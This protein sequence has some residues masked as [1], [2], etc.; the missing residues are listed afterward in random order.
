MKFF[1]KNIKLIIFFFA[2]NSLMILCQNFNDNTL[3]SFISSPKLIKNQL[4]SFNGI[5]KLNMTYIKCNCYNGFTKD[6]NIR[7]INNYDVDCSYFLKSRLIALVLSLIIP[8]GVDYFYLGHYIIG[9]LIFV[10]VLAIIAINIWLLNWVLIYDRLTSVGNVDRIFE[11]K[12]LVLKCT[13]AI[14]DTIFLILYI[15][16]GIFQGL[17]IIKDSNGFST[18][19]DFFLEK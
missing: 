9:F 3:D 18:N 14:I 15:I 12:Y 7:K 2:L 4:C 16:N 8:I 6:K 1:N 17:G 13:V 5:A 11:K 10:L 19:P